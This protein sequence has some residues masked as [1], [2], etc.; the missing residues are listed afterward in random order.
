V[1][2][3]LTNYAAEER[4][5]GWFKDLGLD[6]DLEPCI[7]G[8]VV[9]DKS[10]GQQ[11]GEESMASE[12]W[13]RFLA[14]FKRRDMDTLRAFGARLMYDGSWEL[15][16]GGEGCSEES[17]PAL[18]AQAAKFIRTDGF[19]SVRTAH[20][21]FSYFKAD[22][23]RAF[24]RLN[25]RVEDRRRNTISRFYTV[26]D[27][28][29]VKY[30]SQQLTENSA[31]QAANETI[32]QVLAHVL[33]VNLRS[34]FI[35]VERRFCLFRNRELLASGPTAIGALD[36]YFEKL[37]GPGEFLNWPEKYLELDDAMHGLGWRESKLD[38][39]LS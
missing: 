32:G 8:Y 35:G 21:F 11:I 29:G 31:W 25:L 39:A 2:V 4:A 28:T 33:G 15:R 22:L 10:S 1:G 27:D 24:P 19:R 12:C 9:V 5:R 38:E 14:L 20:E 23:E 36:D 18:V 34:K 17:L 7:S 13:T 3:N 16:V 26:V 37:N 6:L 30:G